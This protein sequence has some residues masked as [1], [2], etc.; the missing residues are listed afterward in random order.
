MLTLSELLKYLSPDVVIYIQV[1]EVQFLDPLPLGQLAYH[2]VAMIID[3]VVTGITVS[4]NTL[5]IRVTRRN[6]A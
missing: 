3:R 4:D 2:K 5:G 6:F 1:D